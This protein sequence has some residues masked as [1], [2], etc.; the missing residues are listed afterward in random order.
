[1]NVLELGI[2]M[3]RQDQLDKLELKLDL[4]E[5]NRIGWC[6]WWYS[7]YY[8]DFISFNLFNEDGSPKQ[9][10]VDLLTD[11]REWMYWD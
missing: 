2:T 8:E 10:I 6:Y 7:W 3:E 1:M 9:E 4:L 5:E 11:Y